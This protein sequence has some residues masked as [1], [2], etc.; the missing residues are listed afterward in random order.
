MTFLTA[1]VL[2]AAYEQR[3]NRTSLLPTELQLYVQI[4]VTHSSK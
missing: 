3:F 2:T 1:S 4:Y